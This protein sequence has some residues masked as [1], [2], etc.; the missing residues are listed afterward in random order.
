[1][2]DTDV[3]KVSTVGQLGTTNASASPT[4]EG[5]PAKRLRTRR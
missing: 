1:M 5:C 3:L 2:Q 4:L